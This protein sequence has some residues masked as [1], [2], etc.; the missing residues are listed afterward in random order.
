MAAGQ[1]MAVVQMVVIAAIAKAMRLTA[2]PET[3][4]VLILRPARNWKARIPL[5][6]LPPA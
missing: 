5:H 1:V 6:S 4:P 3:L 2:L